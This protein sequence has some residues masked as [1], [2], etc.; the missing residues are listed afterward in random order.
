M[1]KR[2][3]I[4]VISVIFAV[5]LTI[6]FAR[7]AITLQ[8]Q[9]IKDRYYFGE[10]LSGTIV[11]DI[12]NESIDSIISTNWGDSIKLAGLIK[13]N[14]LAYFCEPYDCSYKY[15]AY[16]SS[17]SKS[18]QINEN[19]EKLFGF[20][21]SGDKARLTGLKL[22][23][24]SN[25]GKEDEV[26]LKLNFFNRALWV[27]NEPSEDYSKSESWGCYETEIP[28]AGIGVFPHE[29]YD[30]SSTSKYCEKI[31]IPE[32]GY[33]RAGARL[34]GNAQN[35]LKMNVYGTDS[36]FQELG[37]CSF[38]LETG[39][40][41]IERNG[42]WY[43]EG[44]YYF[45]LSLKNP[46]EQISGTISLF[47][48]TYGSSC[49]WYI[50]QGY[51]LSQAMLSPS[52]IDYSIYA[53]TSKYAEARQL[54]INEYDIPN[55]INSAD[56]YLNLSYYNKC[57]NGCVIPIYASGVSQVLRISNAQ[58]DYEIVSSS[59]G[60]THDNKI[61]D[62]SKESA[63]FN[64]HGTLNLENANITIKNTTSSS[65]ILKVNNEKILEKSIA[66]FSGPF[67]GDISPRN[68]P[69]GL[70]AKFNI[71]IQS[72]VNI[73]KYEWNFGDNEST[74]TKNHSAEHT[75][76][77]I[78]KFTLILK[79]TDIN[80][81]SVSKN[82]EI[83]STSP[84]DFINQSLAKKSQRLSNLTSS[85]ASFPEWQQNAIKE[86]INFSV[87][88]S[89]IMSM[90]SLRINALSGSEI[91]DLFLR[92]Q[93]L[94]VP[95]NVFVSEDASFPI[96]S[97]LD[98]INP[99]IIID[100]SGG[101]SSKIEDYKS[102][103]LKWQNENVYSKVN[104]VKISYF[105]GYDNLAPLLNVYFMEIMPNS[106]GESYL[107]INEN[108]DNLYFKTDEDP[109]R[110][111][112]S[113]LLILA[114]NEERSFSFYDLST[115]DVSFFV[116]P[117]LESLKIIESIE[118]CN[119]NGICESGENFIGCRSDCKPFKIASVYILI[120]FLAVLVFYTFL[121][122]WYKHKYE[123][124]LFISRK[125]PYNIIMFI[126]NSRINGTSDWKIRNMLGSQGWNFEQISYC[127]RK[128]DGKRT[129]LPEIIP[130]DKIKLMLMNLK[131]KK[132]TQNIEIPG[133]R[134]W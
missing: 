133:I 60:I 35:E 21:I 66:S 48:E 117:K 127:M 33:V 1:K 69:A 26:P 55:L 129:G 85:I 118:K 19:E 34:E 80:N 123:K 108:L 9:N 2:Q 17:L 100:Y 70:K 79:V 90:E 5:F 75:Y 65:L 47:R 52:Q 22:N 41:D 16:N 42:N 8:S 24:S 121:S 15:T 50:P 68:P 58:T 73:S 110:A 10:K 93:N 49:G 71:N 31:H 82:F 77:T 37:E 92:L 128:A 62:I 56:A 104:R 20:K 38:T 113:T 106:T 45:C 99:Q 64:F 116:S 134:K 103:I 51:T 131:A 54:I 27:F 122:Q 74:Q 94:K 76:K 12:V 109:A 95:S 91:I 96:I 81:V 88:Q 78:G 36:F 125:D 132:K 7:A 120:L 101:D 72:A 46:N 57:S 6:T 111:G 115:Q 11:L 63:R 83:E 43:N 39:Y 40:C 28:T 30:I 98:D 25:F 102:S 107:V 67:I 59:G 44:D 87:I 4:L 23:L 61:Y 29:K 89:E 130:I 124:S 119:F 84:I 114:P 86:K 53:K 105:D 112:E 14:N 32:S 18:I 126:L 3:A 13:K 97:S